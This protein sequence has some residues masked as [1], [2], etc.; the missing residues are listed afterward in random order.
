[1]SAREFVGRALEFIPSDFGRLV[2]LGSLQDRK[3]GA[4]RRAF[5]ALAFEDDA[6]NT[7]LLRFHEEAFQAWLA[8]DPA[9][10]AGDVQ[11]YCETGGVVA[12]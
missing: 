8:R 4:Y 6:L 7:A 5:A 9:S 10:Q 12:R 3:C 2:M 1:M 11:I